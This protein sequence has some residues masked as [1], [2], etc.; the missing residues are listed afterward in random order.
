MSAYKWNR[1]SYE[2]L[3]NGIDKHFDSISLFW[4]SS[5]SSS[6]H[7]ATIALEE[8][9]KA[10]MIDHYVFQSVHN[11]GFPE[12]QFEQKWLKR[13][14]SHT[15]KQ[16]VYV[17]SEYEDFSPTFL[18][19]VNANELEVKKQE[20]VYVGFRR[21]GKW[22]D[23]KSNISKPSKFKEKDA[24]QI[25]SVNNETLI[26]QCNRNIENGFYYGTYQAYHI[27]DS[28]MIDLL[29]DEWDYKS[30]IKAKK[31]ATLKMKKVD[32]KR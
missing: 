28:D 1:L 16:Q 12:I 25:I 14:Y 15:N 31:W 24:R 10:K 17:N 30:G 7:L 18:K 19:F 32:N 27:L 6:F 29:R 2:S 5:F 21:V 8:I 22:I 23:T 4:E 9:A 13:L 11:E 3:I 20:S 26:Q